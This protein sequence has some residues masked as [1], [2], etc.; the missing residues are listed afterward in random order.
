MAAELSW[1]RSVR[2]RPA[3]RPGRV[4]AGS[5]VTRPHQ[6]PG[7]GGRPQAVGRVST[8][9]QCPGDTANR[10]AACGQTLEP[11]CCGAPPH[12][13]RWPGC[14]W[15]IAGR[16]Q[17]RA[18]GPVP[19]LFDRMHQLSQQLDSLSHHTPSDA[20]GSHAVVIVLEL[21]GA[22]SILAAFTSVS[23]ACSTS[24]R[25]PTCSS[26]WSARPCWRWSPSRRSVGASCS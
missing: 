10:A 5:G 7:R 25:W 12:W 21:A 9:A 2:T 1:R 3:V 14:N 18:A 15:P 19:G 4:V 8:A 16:L 23:C 20:G 22:V 6:Y 17:R 11:A 13:T 24:T 26:T